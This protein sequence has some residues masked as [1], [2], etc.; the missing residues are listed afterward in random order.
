[1]MFVVIG[2]S[3][4]L[5][6]KVLLRSAIYSS[7]V[8]L[9]MSSLVHAT[10][11]GDFDR[12]FSAKNEPKSVYFLASYVTKTGDHQLEVWRQAD[13][14][15][16]KT[17]TSSDAFVTK[18]PGPEDWSMVILDHQ[19]KIASQIDRM[20]LLKIGSF[21]DWYDLGHGLTRPFGPHVV[22]ESKSVPKIKVSPIEPCT[23]Y[24]L[25]QKGLTSQVCWSNRVKLP[26]LIVG[27][28]HQTI[29]WRI[30]TLKTDPIRREIFLVN[31][32]GYI[33]NNASKDIM[34]D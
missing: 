26:L 19:K 11:Q 15:R 29:T 12:I 3:V 18:K 8:L 32:K 13:Q 28:D 7:V 1:M 34:D 10:S 21:T 22:M 16:R 4:R 20:S 6:I 31:D 5:M 23:W 2:L 9:Q 25:T 14:L 30:Q 17:D 33:R 27:N 24:D